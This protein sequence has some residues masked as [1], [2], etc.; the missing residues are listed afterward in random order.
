[1]TCLACTHVL[2]LKTGVYINPEGLWSR[3]STIKEYIAVKNKIRTFWASNCWKKIRTLSLGKILLV[4]NKKKLFVHSF[5]RLFIYLFIYLFV[6]L[7]IYF[8]AT[9]LS[10]SHQR[11][12]VASGRGGLTA[13]PRAEVVSG[14][15]RGSAQAAIL[16]ENAVQH[17]K[18]GTALHY[19]ANQKDWKVWE[20]LSL[21]KCTVLREYLWTFL[22]FWQ[23][24]RF[25][26]DKI[27]SPL[28][29]NW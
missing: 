17:S 24:R 18:F 3:F 20:T 10:L 14:W 11:Q 22:F 12:G 29:N 7:F 19:H 28:I 4:L 13:V 25:D 15:G 21:F 1:M 16:T 23:G 9:Y 2:E 6:C 27:F 5:V 8:V 26:R